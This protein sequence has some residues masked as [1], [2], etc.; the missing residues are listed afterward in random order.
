MS[1]L[2]RMDFLLD[3][4]IFL[5]NKFSRHDWS[6]A[7]RKMRLNLR[8]DAQDSVNNICRMYGG[9][10]SLSDLVL[11]DGSQV[12]ILE[13]DEFDRLRKELYDTCQNFLLTGS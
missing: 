10:G 11:Y 13:N 2:D 12:L 5:L 6:D 1:D 9:M 4:M 8:V 3:E 7:L